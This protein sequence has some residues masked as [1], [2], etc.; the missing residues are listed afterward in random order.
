MNY[1]IPN[2]L[3]DASQSIPHY[4]QQ[5]RANPNS[6]HF[7]PTQSGLTD[8]G[9]SI[10]LGFS[11]LALRTYY[12]VGLWD[13]LSSHEQR[14]WIE[15]IQSF[16]VDDDP[17]YGELSKH[18][19]IDPYIMLHLSQLNDWKSRAKSQVRQ[20]VSL[21]KTGQIHWKSK[22][23]H[24]QLVISAETKQAI[25]ILNEVG[26]S[27]SHRYIGYPQTPELIIEFLKKFNWDLPWNAGAHYATLCVYISTQADKNDESEYQSAREVLQHFIG[28]FA[29]TETGG[30]H[31]ETHIPE[32]SQLINGTMKVITGLDWLGIPIHYPKKLID[33]CLSQ[34]P[35]SEGC[36]LVDAVYVL[37]QCLRYTDHRRSDIEAYVYQLLDMI[38]AHYLPD[39]GGFSYHIGRSQTHYYGVQISHGKPGADLHGTILL[40]W[41]IAMINDILWPDKSSWRVVK[42]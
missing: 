16:Q 21:I 30:Y 3:T 39:E 20:V 2:W 37:H 10:Q 6:Y 27:S 32:Y 42:P 38:K 36:H 11:C 17:G 40:S 8:A 9:K 23:P 33:T 28:T 31:R 4:V 22:I 41:A 19:F 35:S 12:I 29:N 34:T 13:Q 7:C 26:M 15:F 25:A 14:A 18:A 5:L 1:Q 24:D